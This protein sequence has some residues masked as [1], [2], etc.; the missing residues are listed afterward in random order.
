MVLGRWLMSVCLC[1]HFLSK[2]SF[3]KTFKLSHLEWLERWSCCFC[4]MHLYSLLFEW[5]WSYPCVNE[6]ILISHFV[7]PRLR[8]KRYIF[9]HSEELIAISFFGLILRSF[10]MFSNLI[11]LLF[12][13]FFS[14]L[15]EFIWC[16]RA[17]KA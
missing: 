14:R 11:N 8:K 5:V 3:W 7:I 10:N 9:L 17:L 15:T 12:A 13:K 2:S 6:N 16:I 1:C 4:S